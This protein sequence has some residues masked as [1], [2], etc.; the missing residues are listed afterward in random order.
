VVRV[1]PHYNPRPSAL[2]DRAKTINGYINGYMFP[3]KSYASSPCSATLNRK[4]SEDRTNNVADVMP[5]TT[6][7][8]RAMGEGRPGRQRQNRRVVVQILQNKG[9]AEGL[10]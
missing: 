2:A 4:L 1:D 5:L 10:G 3:D 8:F 9:I 7:W 6:C